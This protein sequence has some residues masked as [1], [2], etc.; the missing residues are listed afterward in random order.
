MVNSGN[1][2][3]WQLWIVF[4]KRVCDWSPCSLRQAPPHMGRDGRKEGSKRSNRPGSC[5]VILY[6]R[7]TVNVSV[8]HITLK[9]Y[10]D[11]LHH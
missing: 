6:S 3:S 2:D 10:T 11:F 1:M 8:K 7:T 9:I 4:L 5:A